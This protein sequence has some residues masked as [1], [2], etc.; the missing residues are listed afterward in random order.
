MKKI[1][2]DLKWKLK[3]FVLTTEIIWNG[4]V[5]I[6]HV[7]GTLLYPYASSFQLY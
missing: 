4:N 1:K 3:S 5:R 7:S 6:L 2:I